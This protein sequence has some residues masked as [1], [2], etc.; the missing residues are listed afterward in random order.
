MSNNLTNE[1][2]QLEKIS[3]WWDSYKYILFF[4]LI[5]VV[6][7]ILGWDYL[8]KSNASG[9]LSAAYDYQDFLKNYIL[10]DS[11]S[12]GSLEQE[13]KKIKVNYKDYGYADLA[14][15]HLAKYYVSNK[16]LLEAE[17]ELRWILERS[18]GTWVKS[19]GPL[20]L[21]SRERLSRLLL[22]QDRSQ[23]VLDLIGA[24]E[25]M[26]SGLYELQADAYLAQERIIEAKISYL[27]ALDLNQS[28]LLKNLISIK[29]ADLDTSNE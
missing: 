11:T 8:K 22:S 16:K 14:S 15:L 3:D 10:E 27:Q 18:K 19:E 21:I 17:T 20:G 24:A 13:A 2:E 28:P 26:N 9:S 5:G 25:N 29:I 1:D 4:A 23:E 6:V 7:A 12:N